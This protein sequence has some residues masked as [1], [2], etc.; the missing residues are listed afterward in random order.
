MKILN[1]HLFK[2]FIFIVIILFSW[3]IYKYVS[4]TEE[5]N[6]Q[7]IRSKFD[8]QMRKAAENFDNITLEE[9][10]RLPNF[11][12]RKYILIK[13][14]NRFWLIPRE[15]GGGLNG[16]GIRWPADVNKLLKKKWKDD[17][18][19]EY[20]FS[21]FMH[22]PQYYGETKDY[23]GR[24]IYS[25]IPCKKKPY[26]NSFRWNG[27][28]ISRYSLGVYIKDKN[29]KFHL[30][31]PN[32]TEEQYLDICLTSLKILNEKIREIHYVN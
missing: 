31:N 6:S 22:S 13:R 24:E 14:N 5:K 29:E 3:M 8:Y 21:I 26:I 23:L 25:N 9:Q 2:V 4:L 30:E 12:S 19:G 20:I 16:F 15:Y 18:N 27:I 11:D 17:F 7:K 10:A 1:Y 32:L 28:L